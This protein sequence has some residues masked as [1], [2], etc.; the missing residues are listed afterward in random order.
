MG[1]TVTV[2]DVCNSTNVMTLVRGR[3]TAGREVDLMLVGH[4]GRDG[5]REAGVGKT[6][7]VKPPVWDVDLAGKSWIV[8][9]QWTVVDT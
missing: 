7:C 3:V 5:E 1:L 9:V 4:L 2:T 6:L 8:C